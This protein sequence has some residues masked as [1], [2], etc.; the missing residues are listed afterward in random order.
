M[1]N[2]RTRE[3]KIRGDAV[4]TDETNSGGA[5]AKF[6]FAAMSICSGK[7]LAKFEVRKTPDRIPLLLEK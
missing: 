7:K 1:A 3:G 4:R 6:H 5:A 2:S